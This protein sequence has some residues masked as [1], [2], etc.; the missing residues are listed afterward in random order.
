MIEAIL[1]ALV[2]ALAKIIENALSGDDYDPEVELQAIMKM[3]RAI[4]D[5]RMA[6]LL[7]K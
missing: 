4:H 1:L 3:Q 2:P 6:R 5:A 7:N